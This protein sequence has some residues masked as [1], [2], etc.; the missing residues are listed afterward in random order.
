LI[1]SFG[2]EFVQGNRAARRGEH[3]SLTFSFRAL[4]PGLVLPTESESTFHI[5]S[6]SHLHRA[7]IAAS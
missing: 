6:V 2:V 5:K 7:F 1:P 4:V 3:P